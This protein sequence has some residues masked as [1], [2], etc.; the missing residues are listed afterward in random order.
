[1]KFLLLVGY[2]RNYSGY[3]ENGIIVFDMRSLELPHNNQK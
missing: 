2:V 3:Y 1:M